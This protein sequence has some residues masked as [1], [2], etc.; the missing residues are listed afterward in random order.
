MAQSEYTVVQLDESTWALDEGLV[1]SYLLLGQEK[2]LLIDTGNGA[3]DLAAQVRALTELPVMLVN[4]HADGDHMACNEVYDCAWLHPSEFDRYEKRFP[5][6]PHRPLLDGEE[7]ELGGRRVRVLLIPGHTPGSIALLDLS[8]RQLFSGD[9]VSSSAIFMFGEG[10]SM[11]ALHS[12]LQRLKALFP[13]YD[14]I[15]PAHGPFPLEKDTVERLLDC[16]EACMAGRVEGR[17][18]SFPVDAKEYSL[19]GVG[20]FLL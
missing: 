7:I 1:R 3:G 11:P 20:F 13:E 5:R 10:R 16:A 17:A 14:R 19:N 2:A 15:L 12:S 9:S 18:P 4:T 8:H 6:H